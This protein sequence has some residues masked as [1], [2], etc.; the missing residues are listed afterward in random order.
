[1]KLCVLVYPYSGVPSTEPQPLEVLRQARAAEAVQR[2]LAALTN[3]QRDA[4]TLAFY[5][6]LSHDEIAR[7]LGRPVGTV[8]SWIRRSLMAMRPTLVGH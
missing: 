2:C 4:L 5:D 6:G 1:M 8:K 7:E 3:E